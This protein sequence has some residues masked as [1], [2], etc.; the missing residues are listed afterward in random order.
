MA[1]WKAEQTRSRCFSGAE[2]EIEALS[3][4]PLLPRRRNIYAKE[5]PGGGISQNVYACQTSRY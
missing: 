1:E 2:G 5:Q 3:P 4:L